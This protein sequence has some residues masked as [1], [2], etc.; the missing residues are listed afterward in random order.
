MGHEDVCVVEE[1]GTEVKNVKVGD[2]VIG[3]F[4]ISDTHAWFAG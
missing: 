2:F 4:V 3:S 1:V